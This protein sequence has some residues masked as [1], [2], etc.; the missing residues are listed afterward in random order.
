MKTLKQDILKL[1]CYFIGHKPTKILT[2]GFPFGISIVTECA[3]CGRTLAWKKI[4]DMTPDE[5]GEIYSLILEEKIDF[6]NYSTMNS[7]E[8]LNDIRK[9]LSQ[10]MKSRNL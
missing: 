8:A 4:I 1:R 6:H 7:V 3:R 9:K 10:M 5:A 2:A